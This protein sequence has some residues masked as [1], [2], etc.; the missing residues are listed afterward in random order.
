[1]KIEEKEKNAQATAVIMLLMLFLM[2]CFFG[3]IIAQGQTIKRDFKY[4]S[5]IYDTVMKSP[6]QCEYK[7]YKGGG[8]VSRGTMKFRENKQT[9]MAWQFSAVG[10][11]RGHLCNFEDMANNQAASDSTMTMYN[12]LPMT[13]S[14]NRGVWKKLEFQVRKLSQLDTISVICGGTD[15]IELKNSLFAPKVCYKTYFCHKTKQKRYFIFSNSRNA[16]M[17]EVSD[18][19]FNK[20]INKK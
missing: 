3:A 18:I 20:I 15:F 16:T 17:N 8:N 6:I 4:Y 7:L 13:I 10:L 14:L 19:E 1:M 2:F 11:D 12:V 5:I 9:S